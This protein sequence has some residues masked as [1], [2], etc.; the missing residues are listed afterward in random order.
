MSQ[1]SDMEFTKRQLARIKQVAALDSLIFFGD[2]KDM[3][4]LKDFEHRRDEVLR[5]AIEDILSANDVREFCELEPEEL[6]FFEDE[7]HRLGKH[8]NPERY[9]PFTLYVTMESIL[10]QFYDQDV[11]D[12]GRGQSAKGLWGKLFKDM[13]G[14]DADLVL[15]YHLACEILDRLGVPR[16]AI[17]ETPKGQLAFPWA[18]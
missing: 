2:H 3:A 8:S 6:E 9:S 18:V 7:F 5:Y 10:C 1:N 14:M 11:N 16:L 12:Y 15:A 17:K 13:D 4:F